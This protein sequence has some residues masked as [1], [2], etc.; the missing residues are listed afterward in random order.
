MTHTRVSCV[1][2]CVRANKCTQFLQS[3]RVFFL[4][5]VCFCRSFQAH[6]L[7]NCARAHRSSRECFIVGCE[8]RRDA[9]DVRTTSIS[10]ASRGVA[11]FSSAFRARVCVCVCFV[12]RVRSYIQG[13]VPHQFSS[14]TH[15]HTHESVAAHR[16]SRD[17]LTRCLAR[18]LF[19]YC[20]S[21]C[22]FALLINL[23]SVMD[24]RTTACVLFVETNVREPNRN[25]GVS[26]CSPNRSE[27]FDIHTNM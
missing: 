25:S 23:R 15:R 9:N 18:H 3:V 12:V 19:V 17:R 10:V 13:S 1:R 20:R 8:R 7:A 24:S 21:G 14:G 5:C 4:V 27:A 6:S 26:Y 16:A 22:L 11:R 2:A